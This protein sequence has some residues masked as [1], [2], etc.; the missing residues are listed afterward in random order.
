VKLLLAT[1]G[2]D[3]EFKDYDGRTPSGAAMNAHKANVNS[4]DSSASLSGTRR[5]DQIRYY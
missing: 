5:A 2:V 1:D 4:K 3:L